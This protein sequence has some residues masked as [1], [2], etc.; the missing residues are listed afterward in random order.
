MAYKKVSKL[1]LLRLFLFFVQVDI[2]K[3]KPRLII[4]DKTFFFVIR[5]LFR[6]PFEFFVIGEAF[7]T[8][9]KLKNDSK[10]VGKLRK[11]I[12][13]G[14]FWAFGTKPHASHFACVVGDSGASTG[15]F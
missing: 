5:L 14:S 7:G 9:G 10:C 12:L 15:H 1:C 3:K 2:T 4:G 8:V 13:R 6:I 11:S